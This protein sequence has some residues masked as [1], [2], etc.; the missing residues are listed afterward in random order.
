MTV[1]GA[2]NELLARARLTGNEYRG[3]R[4]RQTADDTK[5]IL[6]G[7]RLAEY[8][9]H[10]LSRLNHPFLAHTFGDRT[11]DQFERMINIKRLGQ[12]LVGA[13]LKRR[14]RTLQIR[15]GGHDDHWQLRIE[16]LRLL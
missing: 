8:F 15:V 14:H 5:D 4:L 12:V 6:H 1:Q 10:R 9:R 7:R 16:F 13:S 3:M 11:A 2:G